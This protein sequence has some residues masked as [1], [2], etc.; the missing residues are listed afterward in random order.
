MY[1]VM[2]QRQ[3]QFLVHC[4]IVQDICMSQALFKM[5]R[6]FISVNK[7]INLSEINGNRFEQR[8]STHTRFRVYKYDVF[9][10]KFYING[11]WTST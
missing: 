8:K 7:R 1:N 3:M 11:S 10:T 5:S 4:A 6:A 2:L 9:T